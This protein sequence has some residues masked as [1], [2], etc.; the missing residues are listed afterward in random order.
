MLR[1]D[2]A[3]TKPE[4]PYGAFAYVY[5]RLMADMPYGEWLGWLEAYW[6]THGRPARVADL[7]CGTGT[8]AI[9]LAQAGLAVTG[10]DLSADMIG[11]A[12]QKEASMRAE[13]SIPGSLDWQVGD[14]R[15]WSPELPFDGVVSLCDCLNY[16]TSEADL[17]RAFRRA[18]DALRPGGT[19]LFDMHH[20]NQLEEYM[21]HE[22]FC[23][24][25]EEVSYIWTCALDEDTSTITHRLA[26]FLQEVGDCHVKTVETHRQR[27]YSEE[28]VRRLLRE[29]GFGEIESFADFSFEPVD[30]DTTLRMFFAAAKT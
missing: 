20:A 3:P 18:F 14:M 6:G 7:G 5:D 19:F 21:A 1:H 25:E 16:L 29:A 12:R 23:L 15:E 4:G 9:P 11:V 2:E 24:E 10:V 27:A 26:F 8:I 28:T 22:P 13:L 30:D 17:L